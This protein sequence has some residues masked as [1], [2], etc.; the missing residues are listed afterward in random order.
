MLDRIKNLK[1]K[2]TPETK[3]RLKTA[4]IVVGAGVAGFAAV[5]YLPGVLRTK[6]WERLPLGK[7][8][9]AMSFARA[10]V[11]DMD[12]GLTDFKVFYTI[13]G[14]DPNEVFERIVRAATSQDAMDEV[15]NFGGMVA[16]SWEYV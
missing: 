12:D 8:K 13:P 14:N 16:E 2:L 1:N 7:A 5:K 15:N 11:P 9:S 3:Q 4:A 10:L 6:P